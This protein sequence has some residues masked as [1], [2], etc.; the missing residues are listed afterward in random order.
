MSDNIL[1]VRDLKKTYHTKNGST[2]EAV[3]GISFDVKR[4]QIFGFLGANGA[5]KSTTISML[6]TQLVTSG[7]DAKIDGISIIDDPAKVRSKIG[8]VA[9]HNNLDR[10]L[11]ARE[12]LIFHAKYFGMDMTVAN[13]KADE[14]LEKFGLAQR[15]NDYV[16]SYSGG[17]AQRLKIARAMMHTP[18]ILFLDEPT[19]GLDPN[20]R[21]ILWENM[22]ELNKQGTTIFLT[23]HYMEEPERFCED[24]AIVNKG[25]IKA[26][27][28]SEQL[29]AMIPG[30]NIVSLKLDQVSD[31][32]IRSAEAL[33][34]VQ[35][36][37]YQ[38]GALHLYLS[39]GQPDLDSIIKWTER[40]GRTMKNI[41]LS[42]NTLDD[43]FLY[44][45]GDA[46]NVAE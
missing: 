27:G 14:Y 24:I 34:Q 45:T 36:V 7:G 25:E 9:Q 32:D 3:K 35:K 37:N 29:K 39:E 43:V 20:Y 22:M 16:S 31:E 46:M 38:G 42:T 10:K 18:E 12:N 30:K 44:L 26:Q 28:T 11:T 19:T 8:V 41:S 17:M 23:T 5:G 13:K 4:G 1:E 40:Q 6:T 2:V 33:S 21:E 15:Q